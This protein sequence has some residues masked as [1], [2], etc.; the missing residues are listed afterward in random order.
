MAL[1]SVAAA[2]AVVSAV[3]ALDFTS[4]PEVNQQIKSYL[5]PLGTPFTKFDCANLSGNPSQ[6]F[7]LNQS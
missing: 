2:L 1:K 7:L 4:C 6:I 3:S 5:A